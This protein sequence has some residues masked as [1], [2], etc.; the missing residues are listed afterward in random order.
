MFASFD[1]MGWGQTGCGDGCF[2]TWMVLK[3]ILC[4]ET[5][6]ALIDRA[7][8][9]YEKRES[10]VAPLTSSWLEVDDCDCL[11]FFYGVVV[12]LS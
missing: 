3:R 10:L 5:P 9:R 1:M 12:I 2:G 11:S 7:I 4:D 8:W 6:A